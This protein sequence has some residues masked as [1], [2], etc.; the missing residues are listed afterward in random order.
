MSFEPEDL[1]DLDDLAPDEL[2]DLDDVDHRDDGMDAE[3]PGA[4]W[5]TCPHCGEQVE[6]VVDPGGGAEQEYVED[7][8][9]CCRPWHVRVTYDDDGEL[10]V[11]L[12]P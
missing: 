7:C 9:V 1:D 11:T 12:G 3:L 10:R 5:A 8:E 4:A 6:V 2:D